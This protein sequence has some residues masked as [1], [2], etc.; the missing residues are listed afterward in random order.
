MPV[1]ILNNKG[2]RRFTRLPNRDSVTIPDGPSPLARPTS[3]PGLRGAST[4]RILIDYR[5]ALHERT[6]VGEHIHHLSHALAAE[7]IG[8]DDHSVTLFSS[9]WR[10]R[11]PT[12]A[13]PGASVVD[14]RVPVRTLNWLW[15][16]LAWPPVER[17]VGP[18]DIA[19]SPHPLAMPTR[20]AARF[21]TVH[22]LDFL[23]HPERTSA[24]IRRDYPGLVRRHAA[25][26]DRVVVPSHHTGRLVRTELGVP[27]D[28]IIICPN[29]APA[30][31]A[32]AQP[33]YAGP[34]LFVGSLEPR[35]NVP[36]LVRAYGLLASRRAVPRLILA[37]RA[38]PRTLRDLGPLD[39]GPSGKVDLLG[40][41][42]SARR[43]AL[44]A[45][46]SMLV[47]PSLDEGFGLPLVEA[48]AVG[49]PVVA[50]TR[51]AIPEV[52]GNAGTLVEP[53]DIDGL[54]A[55]MSR[56]LDDRDHADRS[57]ARGLT[58]ARSFDWR[59]SALTLL[60]AY[61]AVTRGHL[62]R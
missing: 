18:I 61:E 25:D 1:K 62:V 9:S 55:A 16:R 12:D 48:M 17:F 23:A 54:A 35:K 49:V 28:R 10:H 57:I 13:V 56:I 36:A 11:L 46:A 26:A 34:I 58:R 42:D 60:A 3:G 44:Y 8:R 50:S 6:G 32:R 5:P 21:I 37:G 22:D 2:L 29:G 14:R 4:V 33:A 19:H 51:G 53:D 47:L 15:H 38:S 20:A 43:Y 45:G 39:V 30:W 27:E 31:P 40:Y 7:L 24:E 59:V 52:V 41:V